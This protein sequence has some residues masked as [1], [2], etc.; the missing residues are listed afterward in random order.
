MS[1]R[2]GAW[3]LGG[4]TDEFN[5]E[6]QELFGNGNTASQRGPVAASGTEAADHYPSELAQRLFL[7]QQDALRRAHDH[8]HSGTTSSAAGTPYSQHDP[9]ELDIE[10]GERDAIAR[11][12]GVERS[13]TPGVPDLTDVLQ[14]GRFTGFSPARG[15][16]PRV[17]R[18]LEDAEAEVPTA[19][20]EQQPAV[21]RP[22]QRQAAAAPG[23]EAYVCSWPPGRRGQS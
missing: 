22:Q 3:D 16:G 14:N 18:L 9:L 4:T 5:N 13:A 21:Q 20:R 11:Q 12:P 17:R 8:H 10:R 19:S 6:M 15:R 23:I 1:S 2:G 7:A